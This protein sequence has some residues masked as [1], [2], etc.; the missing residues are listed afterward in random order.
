L[1][2]LPQAGFLTLLV[3]TFT[4]T[5]TT[6]VDGPASTTQVDVVTEVETITA[7]T[8]TVVEEQTITVTETETVIGTVTQ[9]VQPTVVAARRGLGDS[10]RRKY[11]P[12]AWA[13]CGSFERYQSACAR[14]GVS[15]TTVTVAP[16]TTVTAT[17]TARI[18]GVATSS[19]TTTNATVTFT[20]TA[21]VTAVPDANIVKNGG[22]ESGTL[23][24]WAVADNST[25]AVVSP[26]SNSAFSLRFGPLHGMLRH[27]VS[28]TFVGTPGTNYSC[29]YDWMIE[30]YLI[31]SMA[32]L[33]IIR[34]HINE[35]Q[36]TNTFA[37]G[38][39]QYGAWMKTRST[40]GY[41]STGSDAVRIMAYSSQPE[42]AGENFSY[43]D[44]ISCVPAA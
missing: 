3:S 23:E 7:S 25:A 41:E 42:S 9:T 8:E 21:T 27:S 6:T 39:S 12:Y 10:E 11:P 19:T 40:F 15:P 22:F 28:T 17:E 36:K 5:V 16:T 13:A 32:H 26:G 14:V 1:I 35:Q 38:T 20:V 4:T 33:P 31:D 37:F 44:N 29:S 43:V 30:K 34:L 24:G 2:S 18:G